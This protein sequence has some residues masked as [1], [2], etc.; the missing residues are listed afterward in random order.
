M[1]WLV[2]VSYP[3]GSKFDHRIV[4][5]PSDREQQWFGVEN[6]YPV[7]SKQDWPMFLANLISMID[8]ELN[9]VNKDG[10]RAL[11]SWKIEV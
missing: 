3:N 1:S 5:D 4:L 9:T 2:T 6:L 11:V 8:S 7:F 10:E